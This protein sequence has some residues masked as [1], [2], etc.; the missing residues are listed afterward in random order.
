MEL[1]PVGI[2]S[3]KNGIVSYIQLWFIVDE[4]E[5]L[6]GVAATSSTMLFLGV[7]V[8]SC[9]YV[10]TYHTA[11]PQQQCVALGLCVVVVLC[12]CFLGVVLL[13]VS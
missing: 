5:F 3:H 9:S 4:L 13:L 1:G 8:T 12:C 6:G 10:R 7:A 2:G 11:E